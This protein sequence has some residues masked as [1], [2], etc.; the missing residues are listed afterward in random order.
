MRMQLKL[1]LR[2]YTDW[3]QAALKTFRDRQDVALEIDGFD[4]VTKME[5]PDLS[6]YDVLMLT[7]SSMCFSI[8]KC[9]R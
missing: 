8:L 4:V 9:I 6:G 3:L 2:I 7:G 5:Y 1:D